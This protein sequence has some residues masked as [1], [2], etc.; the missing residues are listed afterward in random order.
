MRAVLGVSAAPVPVFQN[1]RMSF[2]FGTLSIALMHTPQK[3]FF[4][5]RCGTL[6]EPDP[7]PPARPLDSAA[8]SR[9]RDVIIL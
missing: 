9:E 4:T 1:I 6:S 3:F 5:K 8:R 2:S 7:A